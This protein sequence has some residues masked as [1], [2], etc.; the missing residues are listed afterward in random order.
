MKKVILVFKALIEVMEGFHRN[1]ID[2]SSCIGSYEQAL[3]V[4]VK[5]CL[6]QVPVSDDFPIIVSVLLNNGFIM[7]EGN[8]K[9]VSL[10]L[11]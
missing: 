7:E 11:K 4:L 2:L 1:R 8:T 5:Y 10:I 9:Y 6:L 3:A